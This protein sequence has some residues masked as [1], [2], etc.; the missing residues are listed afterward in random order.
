MP[1]PRHRGRREPPKL[2]RGRHRDGARMQATFPPPITALFS[3]TVGS[4]KIVQ[5]PNGWYIVHVSKVT[6]VDDKLLAPMAQMSR[7]DLLQAANEEYLAQLA[8]AAKIA[9]GAK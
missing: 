6:P 7:G 4:A 3:T 2:S 5:A 1:S 8:G 9:V